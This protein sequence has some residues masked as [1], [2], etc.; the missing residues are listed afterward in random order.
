MLFSR[1]VN[2][3]VQVGAGFAYGKSSHVRSPSLE[4]CTV[5]INV[6]HGKPHIK[7][8]NAEVKRQPL[9]ADCPLGHL[10]HDVGE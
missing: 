8:C 6:R 5:R 4:V 10:P 2:E 3:A 1:L 9:C 7:K